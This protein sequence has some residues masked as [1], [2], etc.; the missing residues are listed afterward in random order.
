MILNRAEQC[1]L[2]NDQAVKYIW[3]DVPQNDEVRV[4]YKLIPVVA[5]N[6][7]EPVIHGTFSYLKGDETIGIPIG[8]GI[9]DMVAEETKSSTEPEVTEEEE[10]E[11]QSEPESDAKSSG[12]AAGGAVVAGAVAAAAIEKDKEPEAESEPEKIEE[13]APVVEETPVVEEEVAEVKPE[14][15]KEKSAVDGNIVDVPMPETGVY[16]RVQIAAGKT[17][18]KREEFAKRYTFNEDLKLENIDGW[19]KYTTGHH[20]VYKA[21][22]DDRTRITAKYTKFRGPFVAAYN[23]GERITVQEALMITNQKWYQ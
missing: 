22:R 5:M 20:Q 3:Y 10:A 1:S 6:G 7:E 18:V 12:T 9:E 19:F 21:A 4:T 16:Y 11:S 23:D 15:K 13:R 14:P 17:N 8:V 2:L